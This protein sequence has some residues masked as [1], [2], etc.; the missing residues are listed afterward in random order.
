MDINEKYMRDALDSLDIPAIVKELFEMDTMHEY[1]LD[2]DS[3]THSGLM[4][5][6]LKIMYRTKEK[7]FYLNYW[8]YIYGRGDVMYHSYEVTGHMAH[9]LAEHKRPSIIDWSNC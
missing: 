5:T 6:G 4:N 1:N 2:L 9:L 3:D 8:T 7:K